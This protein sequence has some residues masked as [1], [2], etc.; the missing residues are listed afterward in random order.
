M[1]GRRVL[2]AA[3]FHDPAGEEFGW[4]GLRW[5]EAP[6]GDLRWH[7]PLVRVEGSDTPGSWRHVVDDQGG[8]LGVAYEG[9]AKSG[10]HVYQARWYDPWLGAGRRHRFVLL[11]N[12]DRPEVASEA[13]D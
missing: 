6:P 12:G 8:A 13:F 11:E 4:W 1:P 2:A 5:A 7:E 10:D 3:E 9:L